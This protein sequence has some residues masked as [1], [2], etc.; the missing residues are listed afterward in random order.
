LNN[1]TATATAKA[2]AIRP[3]QAITPAEAWAMVDEL[4]I[5]IEHSRK[6]DACIATFRNDERYLYLP[7]TGPTAFEAVKELLAQIGVEVAYG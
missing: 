1:V 6:S 5:D 2:E 4:K 7:V 3:E